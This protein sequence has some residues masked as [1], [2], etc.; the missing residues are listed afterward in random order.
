MTIG[1][2]HQSL[3]RAS[4]VGL[5]CAFVCSLLLVLPRPIRADHAPFDQSCGS[6]TVGPVEVHVVSNGSPTCAVGLGPM[7]LSLDG[8]G[9]DEQVLLLKFSDL[10]GEGT[11]VRRAWLRLWDATAT[12]ADAMTVAGDWFD[13]GASCDATDL[14]AP[15]TDSALG[16]AGACGSACNLVGFN[17]HVDLQL[18]D[19]AAHVRLDGAPFH[20]R[21]RIHGGTP[22]GDNALQFAPGWPLMPLYL[23][24]EECAA[25]TAPLPAACQ[26][27]TFPASH[28]AFTLAEAVDAPPV[29]MSCSNDAGGNTLLLQSS[30]S[31][32]GGGTLYESADPLLRFDTSGIPADLTPY[33]ALLRARTVDGVPET[34]AFLA[35]DWFD[36]GPTC[37]LD[38]HANEGS[39]D[40]L[41]IGSFCGASC[42]LAGIRFGTEEDFTLTNATTHVDPNGSSAFRLRVEPGEGVN[43]IAIANSASSNGPRL[44]VLACEDLE[45]PVID[46]PAGCQLQ[47]FPSPDESFV[48]IDVTPAGIPHPG[49][50]MCVTSI[51]SAST[52]MIV[53]GEMYD[54]D[55]VDLLATTLLRWSTASLPSGWQIE[56]AWLRLFVGERSDAGDA[57]L[58]ADWDGWGECDADDMSRASQSVALSTTGACGTDCELDQLTAP[59]YVDLPLDNAALGI[60]RGAGAVTDLRLRVETNTPTGFN[61]LYASDSPT[62][63]PGPGL[64]VLL[65]DHDPPAAPNGGQIIAWGIVDGEISVTG[66]P[67]SVE[68]GAEVTITNTRT[69]LHVVVTANADGSFTAPSLDVEALD[70]LSIVVTDG[71]GNDSPPTA[72]FVLPPEPSLVAPAVDRTVATTVAD[73]TQFLYAGPMALQVGVSPGTMVPERASVIRG[74]VES[75]D[76]APLSGVRITVLDHPEYGYTYSRPDGMFDLAVNGGGRL[77]LEYAGA[78]SFPAQRTVAVPWQGFAQAPAVA[79]VE[80]DADATAVTLGAATL[81]IA[82]GGPESDADGSREAVLLIPANTSASLIV[83]GAPVPA[84]SLTVRLTEYTVGARGPAAMPG[85]LPPAS[86]Y[87]YAVE[88][89]ADEA[90]AAG[91]ERVELSQPL[92]LY[93]DNFIGFPVGQAVPL[94]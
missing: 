19:A 38:D 20:L 35:G 1:R 83:G 10:Y 43:E 67:G 17:S 24:V 12:S 68:G 47:V 22:S 14:S 27:L 25:V 7:A 88:I 21:L 79:L 46:P 49:F 93:V 40:A 32:L 85:E 81:Q 53:G 57:R 11:T 66:G 28:E 8:G 9:V 69:G 71:A 73:S 34:P 92:P 3:L 45:P 31:P 33:R 59:A 30:Q 48:G 13:W 80:A 86:A 37:D 6:H 18:D 76:G 60:A 74:V 56:D 65:C 2:Q 36:W 15:A 4:L 78:D 87:T 89:S 77:T 64:V 61:Y 50:F 63:L 90:L 75:R 84:S 94:G 39:G 54:V 91:A 82:A 26:I 51:D 42:S 70:E 41:S 16:V 72:V 58:A 62:R 23:L 29:P 5:W 44:L 55:G 52:P